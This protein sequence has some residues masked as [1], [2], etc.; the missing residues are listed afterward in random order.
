MKLI[1]V[2]DVYLARQRSLGMRFESAG[3]LLHHFGRAVGDRQIGEVTPESVIDFLNGD[4]G[5]TATWALKHRVLSGLFRF[6]ISRGYADRSPLPT[7]LPNLPP[8]QTP[9]VYSTEELRRLLEATSTLRTGYSQHVPAMYRTMILLLYGTGMRIGE[10]L[11]LTLKD[12]D[13][14]EDVITIHCTK[15][16]KT[17]L[18]PIGPKLS[19]E[20]A[21]HLERRG[22][23]PMPQGKA[24][25]L[26]ASRGIRGWTYQ[27]VVTMF[28][29]VRRAAGI[30]RP[31]GELRP[32][33]IHDL[34]HTAAVH[35]VVAWYHSGEDVQRL[36]P[37]LATFLGHIDIRSTQRYLQMTP[38]LLEAASQRFAQYA[39]EGSHEE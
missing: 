34:R 3:R 23:L 15:F 21:A 33:R 30:E 8:Q 12:V 24:A 4:K 11:R 35:R 20:L 25:P 9:Y 16:F 27:S 13:L 14:V 22:L 7:V 39:M 10:A 32:P 26:F 1:D 6:A 38:E 18:V 36:L 19:G 28:Q 5:P 37:Q 31:I 2:I 17:R 29:H